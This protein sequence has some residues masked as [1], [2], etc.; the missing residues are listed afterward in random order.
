MNG[1][2]G[3]YRLAKLKTDHGLIM[4]PL[5][6][7]YL[8]EMG[9]EIINPGD[10]RNN[11]RTVEDSTDY[12]KSGG[13]QQNAAADVFVVVVIIAVIVSTRG[14]IFLTNVGGCLLWSSYFRSCIFLL[15]S[16]VYF[17]MAFFDDYL[18]LAHYMC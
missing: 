14:R 3:K 4:R 17:I 6:R 5:Q 16:S 1:R 11:V 8:L 2:D 10:I 18:F 15:T 12:H 13:V 7:L 9:N